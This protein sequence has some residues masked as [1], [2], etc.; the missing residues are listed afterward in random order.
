VVDL[1]GREVKV[2]ADKNAE[3]GTH[4]ITLDASILS[5]Q[6]YIIRLQTESGI[7]TRKIL[8]D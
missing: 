4:L 3:A 2:L 8:V 7:L 5:R 6:T 1:S